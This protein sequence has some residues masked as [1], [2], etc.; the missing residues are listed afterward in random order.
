ML[1][2]W[3]RI[4]AACAAAAAQSNSDEWNDINNFFVEMS[5]VT[6]RPN[7][8]VY[9]RLVRWNCFIAYFVYFHERRAT[10]VDR[11]FVS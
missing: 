10:I 5:A 7:I 2:K 4:A 6:R 3:D 9:F 11:F 8:Y 1:N